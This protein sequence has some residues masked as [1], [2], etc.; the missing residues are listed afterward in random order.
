MVCQGPGKEG[1][2]DNQYIWWCPRLESPALGTDSSWDPPE[3]DSEIEELIQQWIL[4]LWSPKSSFLAGSTFPRWH[5]SWR[6]QDICP[7]QSHP[8]PVTWL[9]PLPLRSFPGGEERLTFCWWYSTG[10]SHFRPLSKRFQMNINLTPALTAC[11]HLF[12]KINF[13]HTLKNNS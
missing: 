6:K 5:H 2:V 12:T 13:K 8:L 1:Y 9:R 4:H 7:H 11:S 10:P 3:V